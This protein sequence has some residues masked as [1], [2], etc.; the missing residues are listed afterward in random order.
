M[1]GTKIDTRRKAGEMG[2]ELAKRINEMALSRHYPIVPPEILASAR[3]IINKL[4]G[5]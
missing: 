4:E 3:A 1:E 5:K 2:I